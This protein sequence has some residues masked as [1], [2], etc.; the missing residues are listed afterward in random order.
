VGTYAIGEPRPSAQYRTF[1]PIAYP[2]AEQAS[3]G[4]TGGDIGFHGPPRGWRA[5]AAAKDLD[6]T[7]GCV[8]TGSDEEIARIARFVREARPVAILR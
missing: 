1:I 2:T 6:W 3:R 5:P 8:G 4:Y 7:F